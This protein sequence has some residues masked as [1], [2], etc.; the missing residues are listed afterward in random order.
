MLKNEKGGLSRIIKSVDGI[1]VGKIV[2]C[3][4][5]DGEH[6]KHGVIWLV[7]SRENLVSE[8]GVVGNRMHLPDDWM[9]PIKPG[10]LDGV[11]IENKELTTS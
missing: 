1:S 11:N 5:V 2:Q 3:L 10:E 4:T 7:A 8:Y 6:T 9:V